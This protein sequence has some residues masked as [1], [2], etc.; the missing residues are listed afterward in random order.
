MGGECSMH[1]EMRNTFLYMEKQKR[2]DNLEEQGIDGKI[3]IGCERGVW[4]CF[5][6]PRGGFL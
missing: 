2:I 3:K 1:E 4:I 5:I 6:W